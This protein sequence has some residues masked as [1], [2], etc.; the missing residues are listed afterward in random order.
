MLSERQLKI[1]EYIQKIGYLQNNAFSQLFPM[2]SEDTVLNE[3]RILI[4]NGLIK[5]TGSTKGARYIRV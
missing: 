1:M 4:K 2:V 3:L 5:K